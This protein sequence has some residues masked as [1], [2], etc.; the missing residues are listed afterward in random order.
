MMVYY[1][2]SSEFLLDTGFDCSARC[3][4]G[5][6]WTEA[7]YDTDARTMNLLNMP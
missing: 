6:E 3:R 5:V 1:L 4:T 2:L 7:E